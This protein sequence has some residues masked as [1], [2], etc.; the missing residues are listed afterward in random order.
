[1]PPPAPVEF[2]AIAPVIPNNIKPENSFYNC[3]KF[4]CQE[5]NI[6]QTNNSANK[7][8]NSSLSAAIVLIPLMNIGNLNEEYCT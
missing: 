6:S 4:V 2:A 3:C 1:M 5:I 8:L 7:R